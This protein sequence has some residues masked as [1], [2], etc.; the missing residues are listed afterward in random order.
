MKNWLSYLR[1]AKAPGAAIREQ[2]DFI[3]VV[4]NLAGKVGLLA[5][6]IVGIETVLEHHGLLNPD[7]LEAIRSKVAEKVGQKP[8]QKPEAFAVSA[9]GDN[10]ES[11]RSTT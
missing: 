7:I 11:M 10:T 9:I 3:N 5:G 8:E 2:A 6:A 1:R 4:E